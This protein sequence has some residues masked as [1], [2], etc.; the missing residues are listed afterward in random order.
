M[1]ISYTYFQLGFLSQMVKEFAYNA[2]DMSSIPE[3]RR[4]PG[5]GNGFPF[6]YSCL[7][8][9]TDRGA[10]QATVHGVANSSNLH[11]TVLLNRKWKAEVRKLE[12]WQSKH[13]EDINNH[14][15][16]FGSS[17]KCMNGSSV[18]IKI[19]HGT[20]Y[21][22]SD[23]PEFIYY[24]FVDAGSQVPRVNHIIPN[25]LLINYCTIHLL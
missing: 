8:N 17:D 24:R 11:I 18:V 2:G 5:E 16:Y 25:W 13:T 19:P 23:Y 22:S 7:E 10:W 21:S 3:S 1:E 20:H 4:S 12:F 6:Q 9:P 14:S 15:E